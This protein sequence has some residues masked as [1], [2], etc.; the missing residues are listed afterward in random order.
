MSTLKFCNLTAANFIITAKV[1]A[2]SVIMSHLKYNL[3]DNLY[4]QAVHLH[5]LQR[6]EHLQSPSLPVAFLLFLHQYCEIWENCNLCNCQ[7]I[8]EQQ[9]QETF[10]VNKKIPYITKIFEL[11]NHSSIDVT[12]SIHASGWYPVSVSTCD[13]VKYA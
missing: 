4:L 5:M 13:V 6:P 12:C 10:I 2:T 11:L 8:S 7:N 1:Y 9:V 3:T